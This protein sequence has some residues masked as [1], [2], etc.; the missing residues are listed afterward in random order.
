MKQTKRKLMVCQNPKAT[1]CQPHSSYLNSKEDNKFHLSYH[2]LQYLREGNC[3]DLED[4][5]M[6]GSVY[7]DIGYILFGMSI[8][9]QSVLTR[10]I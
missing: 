2:N 5:Q 8:K 6:L 3:V 10:K 1:G 4:A 7:D 9:I